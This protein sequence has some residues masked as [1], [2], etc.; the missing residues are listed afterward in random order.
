MME[1]GL[2][3]LSMREL[4]RLRIISKVM[5]RGMRQME[6]SAI[7][8]I[9]DRQM[10]DIILWIF[11]NGPGHGREKGRGLEIS[12]QDRASREREIPASAS[13]IATLFKARLAAFPLI[14]KEILPALPESRYLLRAEH[15]G[16]SVGSI[17]KVK[18]GQRLSYAGA[19]KSVGI[20]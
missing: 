9:S 20:I 6:A 3:T 2:I 5:D 1:K 10:Y 18:P 13:E 7:L 17:R 15:A 11:G 14:Q 12:D 19:L 4:E 8:G 16:G